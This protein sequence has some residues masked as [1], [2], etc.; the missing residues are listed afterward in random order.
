MEQEPILLSEVAGTP[1]K[2]VRTVY[3]EANLSWWDT[4]IEEL[5]TNMKLEQTR[6]QLSDEYQKR[7]IPQLH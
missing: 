2:E 7:T 3:Q 5:N 6:R 1:I 4:K